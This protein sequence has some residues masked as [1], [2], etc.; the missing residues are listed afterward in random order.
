[1]VDTSFA[2]EYRVSMPVVCCYVIA[3]LLFLSSKFVLSKYYSY[4]LQGGIVFQPSIAIVCDARL[5]PLH[6]F[7]LGQPYG[8]CFAAVE[9]LRAP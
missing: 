6:L 2:R 8:I 4:V 7:R 1:M 9:T 5:L 3:P